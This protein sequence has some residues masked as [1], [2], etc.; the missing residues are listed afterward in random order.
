MY[1]CLTII[2]QIL[3]PIQ[4]ASAAAATTDNLQLDVSGNNQ[5]KLPRSLLFDI[6]ENLH[7]CHFKIF[8]S[9]FNGYIVDDSIVQLLNNYFYQTAVYSI[10]ATVSPQETYSRLFRQIPRNITDHTIHPRGGCLVHFFSRQI[11]PKNYDDRR[12]MQDVSRK[13]DPTYV[14]YHR[15]TWEGTEAKELIYYSALI[16]QIKKLHY[17]KRAFFSVVISLGKVFFLCPHCSKSKNVIELGELTT[18]NITK[19]F[20]LETFLS[21]HRKVNLNEAEVGFELFSLNKPR[22]CYPY[23]TKNYL[24]RRHMP[25]DSRVCAFQLG[26]RLFN[27]TSFESDFDF[28]GPA[29]TSVK[30]A[31]AFSSKSEDWKI[32]KQRKKVLCELA[33]TFISFAYLVSKPLPYRYD[34]LLQPL[35]LWTWIS[36]I[37]SI[38]AVT[39]LLFVGIC[40]KFHIR[41]GTKFPTAQ[42]MIQ[43]PMSVFC[44]L[45]EQGIS[46]SFLKIFLVGYHRETI[47]HLWLLWLFACLVV[48]NSYKGKLFSFLTSVSDPVMPKTL[49]EL[50]QQESTIFTFSRINFG[51]QEVPWSLVKDIVLEEIMN[52]QVANVNFPGYF[53]KLHEMTRFH[54]VNSIPTMFVGQLFIQNHNLP[55]IKRSDL[56]IGS[57]RRPTPEDIGSTINILD[58]K[59]E[60]L[61]IRYQLRLFGKKENW[62]SDAR[63]VEDFVI[64]QTVA[65]KK[66]F[67]YP[68]LNLFFG[69]LRQSG[70]IDRWSRL[71]ELYNTFSTLMRTKN[72]VIERKVKPEFITRIKYSI[73]AEQWLRYVKMEGKYF[74][75]LADDDKPLSMGIVRMVWILGG[76]FLSIASVCF[77]TEIII[78]LWKHFERC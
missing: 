36:V 34:S 6:L 3:V 25:P 72:I 18:L 49:R 45:L 13:S 76:F 69:Q 27:F 62:V 65:V 44:S 31:E 68:I 42:D 71:Y 2:L 53:V 48:S 78:A 29:L 14:F 11:N 5:V 61:R 39:Y 41:K 63:P 16:E 12:F 37:L 70:L 8:V 73:R 54:G 21:Q 23:P 59:I 17:T 10:E 35:D 56:G 57:Q 64:L 55:Q 60:I 38:L 4:K 20:N 9:S 28:D 50:V 19:K 30:D 26:M 74:E 77:I 24:G 52:G 22:S 33:L 43:V 75:K 15:S 32:L 66:N 1:L 40:V 58:S 51:T 47:F 7:F 46:D 67:V